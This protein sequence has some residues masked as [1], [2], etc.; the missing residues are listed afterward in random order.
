MKFQKKKTNLLVNRNAVVGLLLCVFGAIMAA[1]AYNDTLTTD[2][3]LYLPTGYLYLTTQTSRLGFEHPPLIREIAAL[4]LLF[5]HLRPASDFIKPELSGR[6]LNDAVWDFGDSFIH[7]QP[8]ASHELLFFSRLVMIL[9]CMGFGFFFFVKCREL[10]NEQ[11]AFLALA[12]YLLSPM[13]LAHGRL[14]TMDLSTAMAAFTSVY[15][16]VAFLKDPRRNNL[17]F[18]STS[19][20]GALLVKFP[21]LALVPFF[22]GI[23]VLWI[24]SRNQDWPSIRAASLR[25]GSRLL[26]IA[27]LSLVIIGIV[28]EFQIWNYPQSQQISDLAD[29]LGSSRPGVLDKV[30]WLTFLASHA[31][32]RS[33]AHFF[34]GII[35]QFSRQG[36]FGYFM[37]EG[38]FGPWL[39]YYPFGYFAKQPLAF[40]ILTLL[41]L[42][43][44]TWTVFWAATRKKGSWLSKNAAG[45]RSFFQR[46]LFTATALL[47]IAY[48]S[49]ILIFINKGNTGSRYLLPILPFVFSL[50]AAGIGQ[51]ISSGTNARR[52]TI[53]VALLLAWQGYSVIKIFPSFL[54]YFNEAVGGP[55]RGGDYLVDTDLDWGQDIKRLSDWARLHKIQN[56]KLALRYVYQSSGSQP[57]P[58]LCYSGAYRQYLGYYN[59]IDP[60]IPQSGWIA[61]PGRVLKWGQTVPAHNEGWFSDSTKWLQN[62]EP[63]AKIGYSIY[64]YYIP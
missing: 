32:T 54:A 28:Y 31:L 44:F 51:W 3:G 5:L 35:W 30:S 1:S 9:I 12:L 4:P 55:D 10:W 50:V 61:V 24:L 40:H 49:F 20:A 62:Y 16:F 8:I 41:A 52:K 21:L 34:F 42:S 48:Y 17:L 46:R 13:V 59:V 14:V 64:V 29:V 57:I 7:S 56:L 37:G 36:A 63:I 45:L 53:I 18:T 2:E 39:T 15:F 47:W 33:L 26:M 22:F 23:T 58:T 60:G 43:S 19:L 25:Y 11:T 38:S 27:G 6:G